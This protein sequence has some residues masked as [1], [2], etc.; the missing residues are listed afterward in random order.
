MSERLL[1]GIGVSPGIA[2]GPAVIVRSGL[3]EVPHR[4]VARTQ[5]EKEVRR[6]RAAVRDVKRHIAELKARAEDRAGPDQARIFDAKVLMLEDREFLSGIANLIREN[7][8]TAEKAFEFK[9][10]E[11]RDLWAASRSARLKE[12]LA[13]L[14]GL[15]I[16]MIQHLMHRGDED[17]ERISRP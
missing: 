5:V 2:I 12:R 14:N 3:P 13:D 10:L 11:V 1:K 6:L 16:R 15:A 4:V 7:H 8:L 17:L 9:V